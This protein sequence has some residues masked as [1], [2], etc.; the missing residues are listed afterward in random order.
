[1]KLFDISS[2]NGNTA[3]RELYYRGK[4]EYDKN[5][6]WLSFA[7]GE[8]LSFGTYFNLFPHHEY[9]NYC[10]IDKLTLNLDICG[11][12]TVRLYLKTQQGSSVL[13]KSEHYDNASTTEIPL[14]ETSAGGYIYFTLE[15]HSNCTLKGGYWGTDKEAERKVR[16]GIVVC[17]YQREDFVRSNLDIIK[18]AISKEP[19]W[20][21]RLH[22][23]I[24][25]NAQTLQL[26]KSDTYTVIPNRNLGGSGGFARGMYEISKHDEFTH[27]LLMDDDI[28]F[29]FSTLSRTYNLLTAL[30]ERH[31]DA[32]IGGAML[33][34]EQ[35]YIQH[36]FGGAFKGLIFKSINTRLDMREECNL[37]KNQNAQKPDYNA[38]WYCCMPSEF[39]KKYGLPMPFFIKSDDVEYGIRTF[40]ELILMNGIA[41]WHQDFGGK[42][43][44]TLEY[45]IKRNSMITAVLHDRGNRFKAAI[46]YAYFMFKGLSVKNYDSVELI[47][48]SYLDYK[49]GPSYLLN[50]DPVALNEEIYRNTP[51]FIGRE[52]LEKT[53]GH[54]QLPRERTD[55]RHSLPAS[56]VMLMENYLPVCFFSNHVAITDA[57]NPKAKDCF[58][59]KTVIHYS[60]KSNSGIVCTF[61]AVRRKKLR[62]AAVRTILSILFTYGK[63]KKLYRNNCAELC[64]EGHWEKLFFPQS[65]AE[66]N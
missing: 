47:Y 19:E 56:F 1:M 32:S 8:T 66:N 51:Q 64:S 18:S 61:D 44:G 23:F 3:T 29:E 30:S 38:W 26:E 45:Y 43:N 21:D 20:A 24:V 35:P 63:Y 49:K 58:M 22:I 65:K 7:G 13:L 15:A 54:I 16:L 37:L 62:R 12:Y 4:A 2:G 33:K 48:R 52:E 40:N 42:Y 9:H 25:D 10:G 60:P 28:K 59:K 50:T 17:T 14:N 39:I 46:R 55:K 27:V 6:G 34:L 5:G 11:E 41:V 36:E 53:Y 31:S 57:G